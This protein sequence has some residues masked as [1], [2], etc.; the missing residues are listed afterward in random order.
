MDDEEEDEVNAGWQRILAAVM[1]KC[2]ITHVEL[3]LDELWDTETSDMQ[4]LLTERGGN[5]HVSMLEMDIV[6]TVLDSYES[7]AN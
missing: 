6:D 1:T 2:G 5:L 4:L 3:T 7:G